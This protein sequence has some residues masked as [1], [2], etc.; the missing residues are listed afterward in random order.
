MSVASGGGTVIFERREDNG[1][2]IFYRT[3]V[4]IE[5]C[6]KTCIAHSTRLEAVV[7]VLRAVLEVGDLT[8]DR[9]KVLLKGRQE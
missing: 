6:R 1:F 3:C 7:D 9:G 8:R 5:V 2:S 4:H